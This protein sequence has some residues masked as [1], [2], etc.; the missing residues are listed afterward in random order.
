MLS[1]GYTSVN[2]PLPG[3]G[4]GT[5]PTA[6]IGAMASQMVPAAGKLRLR[7]A[8][9]SREASGVHQRQPQSSQHERPTSH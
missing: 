2:G 5:F 8:I 9:A 4:L 3:Q 6:T 7:A 1:V